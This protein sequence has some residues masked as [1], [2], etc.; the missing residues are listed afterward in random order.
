MKESKRMARRQAGEHA[1][2]EQKPNCSTQS[3][4][5]ASMRTFAEMRTN[6]PSL[7]NLSDDS[8]IFASLNRDRTEWRERASRARKHGSELRAVPQNDAGHSVLL[9]PIQTQRR[10]HLCPVIDC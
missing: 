9:D 6:R 5:A 10:I 2:P 4:V 1:N 7:S 3:P 8:D